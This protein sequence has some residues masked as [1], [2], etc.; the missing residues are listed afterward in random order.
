MGMMQIIKKEENK[1]PYELF[2]A[3]SHTKGTYAAY[4]RG[5]RCRTLHGLFNEFSA[6]FQFPSYFSDN[7]DSL[8]ECLCDL[9]WLQFNKIALIIDCSNE[10][11]CTNKR[12]KKVL[13]SVLK[14]AVDFWKENDV[15][16]TVYILDS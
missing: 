15:V 1:T 13:E 5:K 6:A 14:A 2:Y 9:E 7:W 11:L 3:A 10:I 12:E 4:V 16:F 8:D